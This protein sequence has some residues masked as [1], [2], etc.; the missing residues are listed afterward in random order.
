MNTKFWNLAPSTNDAGAKHLDIQMHGVMDGNWL[1]EQSVSTAE[2]I[3][4]IQAHPDAATITLR[5]NSLGG[6]A[7][8]G[9]AL[10][11]ALRAH[12][13]TTTAIVEGL[14][15]SA[16]SLVACACDQTIMGSPAAMLM[17]H[18][19]MALTMGNAAELT[20][21]AAVLEKVTAGMAE[22]YASKT[23]KPVAE[24]SDMLASERWFSASEAVAFGLADS[25]AAE[26]KPMRVA[27]CADGV[28]VQGDVFNRS[29]LP[30]AILAMAVEPE[31]VEEPAAGFPARRPAP[32]PGASAEGL[33]PAKVSSL[34][35]YENP[36]PEERK[37]EPGVQATSPTAAPAAA[38]AAAPAVQ[39]SAPTVFNAADIANARAQ[40][41]AEER[42][43][44]TALLALELP[45][46]A[47]VNSA[48][49]DGSTPEALIMAVH[50]AGVEAKQ[51]QARA[52]TAR[53]D[54]RVA[55]SQAVAGVRV[56]AGPPPRVDSGEAA[57]AAAVARIA[58]E[59]READDRRRR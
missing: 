22:I 40:V 6:S 27:A 58:N 33:R 11:S 13:A 44:V 31:P 46:R 10:A 41:L 32:I 7:F 43:R 19:A 48:I 18:S 29:Q 42:K 59:G 20:A 38:V 36:T 50:L 4:E 17:C 55:E 45:D 47:L 8:G 26:Q 49:A 30:A 56:S 1:D 53:L 15:A 35:E 52:N 34:K 9:I 23:G 57:A 25:I 16:A 39:A 24:I 21:Q 3:R 14:G 5:I 28:M 54:A 37:P 12:P 2:I 51:A